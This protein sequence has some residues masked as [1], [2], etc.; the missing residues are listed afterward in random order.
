MAKQEKSTSKESNNS[1]HSDLHTHDTSHKSY[2]ILG[3]LIIAALGFF[4]GMKYQDY[5]ISKSRSNFGEGQFFRREVGG[6]NGG[7]TQNRQG[8]NGR[9]VNGGAVAGEIINMDDKSI[10]VK[11]PDGSTKIVILTDTTSYSKS[12]SGSKNDLK[13]GT[14]IGAL[15]TANSDGSVTAQNIQLNP[16]LRMFGQGTSPYPSK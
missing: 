3:A 2:M 9:F 15:G 10:T 8:G 6:P 1:V 13:V 14:K 5:K 7:G 11:M 4:S 16:E 12:E